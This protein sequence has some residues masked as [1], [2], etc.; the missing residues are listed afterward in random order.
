MEPVFPDRGEP[1]EWARIPGR[2]P[3]FATHGPEALQEVLARR[4]PRLAV[5]P[6]RLAG[7]TLLF[8]VR[9]D[10]G[11]A[12][13][14]DDDGAHHRRAQKAAALHGG[15]E[16]FEIAIELRQGCGLLMKLTR[17]PRCWL[18]AA[19]T[20][21]PHGPWRTFRQVRRLTAAAAAE[22]L[23]R[24]MGER[25]VTSLDKER[26]GPVGVALLEAARA[27]GIGVVVTFIDQEP[28]RNVYVSDTFATMMGR[29]VEELRDL[30][31][32]DHM[33]EEDR[34][35]VAARFEKRRGGDAGGASAELTLVRKDGQRVS[36]ES[37]S[38]VIDVDGHRAT[39]AF[40]VDVTAQKRAVDTV[41]K[42]EASFRQLIELAPEA[43]GILRDGR[44]IYVNAAYVDVL[45]FGTAEE[46]MGVPIAALVHPDDVDVQRLRTTKILGTRDRVP[47]QIYRVI[48]H[49][50]VPILLEV[51]SVGFE[52]DGG[53]AILS[54][55]RDITEKKRLQDH[56][57][58]AD[59]LA[60]LGT[61]AAGVA[62]EVNNPLAY[63][64]LNLEWLARQL[65]ELAT[66]PARLG[67]LA[68]TLDEAR[69]GAERVGAIVR[70]LRS[71]SRADG[72]TR[73]PVEL[74]AA[75]TS[76]LKI[77]AHEIKHRTKVI[78]SFEDVAPVWAN[79]ARIEQVL[80]N[81]LLNAAQ[82]LPEQS[83][84]TNEIR[85]VVRAKDAQHAIVEISD[86]GVGIAPQTL[87]RIFDPF[88]TTK[89]VGLGT[90]LGLS[91]CHTIVTSLGGRISVDSQLGEGTTFRI[92]LPNQSLDSS[93]A[94]DSSSARSEGEQRAARARVLVVDDEVAIANTLRD[95]LHVDHDVTALSSGHSALALLQAGGEFDVIFCD[96]MMP[97]VSGMDLYDQLRTGRPGA[98]GR[99][100]F[101][102]GGA[103]TARAAEF[104]ARVPN[105]RIE[106]PFSLSTI[107][108][109]VRESVERPERG[110]FEPPRGDA[111]KGRV[112]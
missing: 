36:I 62:H 49:D 60:A 109:L 41:R 112:A 80:L 45:G 89:P 40:I 63:L 17:E 90:G 3:L 67:E 97:Q 76:A 91:I 38:S 111:G 5:G 110:S 100:I 30:A 32:I 101:M 34:Q 85:V 87:R 21:V 58:Q 12:A 37:S 31:P 43:I 54:I 27:A 86:N 10:I 26:L 48:R 72:E 83:A 81:L 6:A 33:A 69:H 15:T 55:A 56:L 53:D 98:E 52:Y 16:R 108:K 66:H 103:F 51:S 1:G 35:R 47:A 19:S 61:L 11:R 105:R 73:R 74:R 50:N 79:E 18:R 88:F 13:Q 75:V 102:T 7:A 65:P 14:P 4:K 39:I 20:S 24:A 29:S 28:P 23:G 78:T 96:L 92:V 71:F 94:R 104:L 84:E 68:A 82:A 95:L 99:M 106:K 44:F 70:E 46:V 59:R 57:V 22:K 9:E 2:I 8:V 42:T 77:A 25:A 93:Q 64:L 107:E